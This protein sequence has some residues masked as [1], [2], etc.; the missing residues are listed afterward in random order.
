[1]RHLR[2]VIVIFVGQD[3]LRVVEDVGAGLAVVQV[4]WRDPFGVAV[5]TF[6]G[7]RDGGLRLRRKCW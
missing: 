7:Y 3:F 2:R 1:M 5:G 4:W 6:S